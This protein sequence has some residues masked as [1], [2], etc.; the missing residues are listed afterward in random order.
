[1]LAPTIASAPILVLILSPFLLAAPIRIAIKQESSKINDAD[2]LYRQAWELAESG[3]H[4]LARV[5]LL[6]AVHLWKRINKSERS[7]QAIL[8]IADYYQR[9]NRWQYALY[10]YKQLQNKTFPAQI[11]VVALN[12]IAQIYVQ[13]YQR[14]LAL[15]YYWQA[16]HLARS[17]KNRSAQSSALIGSAAIYAQQGDINQAQAYLDRARRLKQQY[18]DRKSEAMALYLIGWIYRKLGQMTEAL[19]AFKQ[20]LAIYQQEGD[21]EGEVLSLC[22]LSGLHLATNQK[23]IALEQ[24]EY[25]VEL[26]EKRAKQSLEMAYILRIRDLRWR[27]C[28]MLARAQRALGRLEDAAK[29]YYRAFSHIEVMQWSPITSND[30]YRITFLAERQTPYRELVDLSVERGDLGEA[31]YIAEHARSRA[32]LHLLAEVQRGD[33]QPLQQ[34]EIGQKTVQSIARLRTELLSPQLGDKQR[35]RLQTELREAE[36]QLEEAR[37]QA[38][39]GRL[40]RFTQP[41]S[42]KQVQKAMLQPNDV[43]LG[44]FTGEN[45]SFVWLITS[46]NAFLE[47]LPGQKEIEEKVKQYL[48]LIATKPNSLYLDREI[49]KQ[50]KFGDELFRLLLGKLADKLKPEQRL[51]IAPDG[52][53]YYLPYETLIH[54]G[55]YLIETHEISYIPSASVLGLLQQARAKSGSSDR[56]ELL[57]FGDP[58]FGPSQKA[59]LRGGLKVKADEPLQASLGSYRLPPLPNTRKEVLYVGELFPPDQ[60]RVYLGEESKEEV[61]KR[62]LL[63]R[64]RRLHFATHS[65]INER[66]PSRSAV[67]LT[68]DN[69]PAEDGLLEVHEIA[70]L[71]LDCDLV[72]LSACRTGQGQLLSGEGVVGLTRAFLYAGARSVAVSLWDVTDLSTASFMKSFYRYLLE[73]RSNAA[74]LREAKVDMLRN[75][76]Q[77]RHPYYWAPFVIV[78]LP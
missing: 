77:T 40:N 4:E 13:L 65:L 54:N 61:I 30:D 11:R 25:A 18:A 75:G 52:L 46:E 64:Y 69:D 43:L 8:Q 56:M 27:A 51:I 21:L 55:R 26:V 17:I 45:R 10:Y 74:A 44:F 58:I 47:I 59:R 48:N 34:T 9:T 3:K 22:S 16:L 5:N 35:E 57:A 66:A 62:E 41:A 37:L 24:A 28:F 38:Q 72:V 49:A 76:K 14:E 78:G 6:G 33:R 67:V 53:L 20:A 39:M 32:T 29:S 71:E 31:F 73:N 12:A 23:Q 63:R 42:L 7:A 36:L 50:K 1:M 68:L 19:D 2:A 60:R 15:D 70:D